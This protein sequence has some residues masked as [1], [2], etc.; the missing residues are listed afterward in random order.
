MQKL[1]KITSTIGPMSA[2]ENVLR[3]MIENGMNVCRLNFSHDAKEVHA[4]RIATI[5]K[6]SAEF[7]R[8]I[9]IMADLQG[10]KNR[11]GDF[12]GTY[13]DDGETHRTILKIGQ[14]FTFDSNPALGDNTRVYMPESFVLESLSVGD[15][16]LLNDGK[17]EMQVTAKSPGRID[18]VVIRGTEIWDRR[19]FNLPDTE[20]NTSVL[21]DKDRENLDFVLKHNPDFVAISFVQKPEDVTEVRNFITARTSA[22][23]KIIVKIERP[24][25]V[26]RFEEIAD[27]ADAVMVARGDLAVEMPFWE[28][29]A[30]QRYL[31]R[32]CRKKNRPIIVAT[33]MLASMADNEFPLRSEI[34]DVATAAY[35]RADSVMTSEETTIGHFPVL[36]VET[37]S[38][39]LANADTDSIENSY[40]WNR[41]DNIPE[42]NVWIPNIW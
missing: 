34:S 17:M 26:E 22:P 42:N 20:V 12:A 41:V 4:E 18:A 6:L 31:I 16:I 13:T 14:T 27:V 23:V 1:T 29:P 7:G 3:Q 32:A 19:G 36:V 39:I 5:R 30:I 28:I 38:K 9:A 33:Q 11:I 40:D 25:G 37:M 2:P 8:P 35:L 10:P 21:T 24:Q 15:R